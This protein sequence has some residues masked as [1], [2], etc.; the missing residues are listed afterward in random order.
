M[1]TSTT[2]T[3]FRPY[4]TLG[5]LENCI[6]ALKETNRNPALIRYLS[7][8][9][10]K[11]SVGKIAPQLVTKPTISD[12]LGLSTSHSIGESLAE[13]RLNAY[14]KW[15]ESPSKCSIQELARARMYRYENDLM[16]TEEEAEYELSIDRGY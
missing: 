15:K 11:V 2:N 3:K 16:S 9:Q 4:L 5:E 1:V 7:S 10:D 12:K 14:L 8:F 13:Q 6:N